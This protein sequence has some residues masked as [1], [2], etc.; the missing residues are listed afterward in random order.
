MGGGGSLP[1]SSMNNSINNTSSMMNSGVGGMPPHATA[2]V[3][4]PMH[5]SMQQHPGSPSMVGMNHHPRMSLNAGGGPGGMPPGMMHGGMPPGGMPPGAAGMMG[6]HHHMGG[7]HMPPGMMGG[8]GGGG[9]PQMQGNHPASR[10]Y[11]PSKGIDL[12]FFLL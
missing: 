3:G 1:N 8:P 9:W 4:S 2:V 11:D 6:G 5:N 7:G 12:F 10:D